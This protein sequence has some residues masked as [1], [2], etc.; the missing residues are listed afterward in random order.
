[1]S[2]A[3][4]QM[5]KASNAAHGLALLGPYLF[6][7][8]LSTKGSQTVCPLSEIPEHTL[9]VQDYTCR[10][11][12]QNTQRAREMREIWPIPLI[13]RIYH[14]GIRWYNYLRLCCHLTVFGWGVNLA[15]L[16]PDI[17][18]APC[19]LRLLRTSSPEESE[20]LF[21]FFH[22]GKT[23][24]GLFVF[25]FGCHLDVW[26]HVKSLTLRSLRSECSSCITSFPVIIIHQRLPQMLLLGCKLGNIVGGEGAKSYPE[27]LYNSISPQA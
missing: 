9:S 27:F 19:S 3:W 7:K 14:G 2:T 25:F 22:L 15:F 8:V 4:G 6:K 16:D 12:N 10:V 20:Q 24:A 17:S 11:N 18:S 23:S 26:Q 13:Y 1:M 5:R 21:L